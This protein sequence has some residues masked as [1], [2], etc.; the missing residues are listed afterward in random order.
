MEKLA[1][2]RLAR[3]ERARAERTEKAKR[4]YGRLT[5]TDYQCLLRDL[6]EAKANRRELSDE[7]ARAGSKVAALLQAEGA[8]WWLFY[9]LPFAQHLAIL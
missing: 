9:E 2:D 5:G 8:Y 6:Q 4:T 1:R 3:Q 7:A